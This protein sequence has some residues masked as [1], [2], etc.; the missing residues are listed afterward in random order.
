MLLSWQI[1]QVGYADMADGS[2]RY[3]VQGCRASGDMNTALGN[4]VLMCAI[5]H[6]YLQTLPCKWRFINDGD[7]CGI[8]MESD[9]VHYLDTLPA[10]HLG[11]GFEME[12]EPPV[13]CVEHVEF[14]QSRPIELNEGEWMMVRNVH[15]AMKNDWISINSH[16]W[17]STEEILH[18]TSLCGLALFGDV[19]VLGPMYAAM[20][21][22]GAREVVLERLM[23][24]KDGWRRHLTGHRKY[25]VDETIARVSLYRAFNIL[26]DEQQALEEVY[27]AFD[28]TNTLFKTP[29]S[30]NSLD[31]IRY[32]LD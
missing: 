15:K 4:V 19:P 17:C 18:A 23:Q 1:D 10:H 8:F 20:N 16:D 13:Y 2:V 31:R 21:R 12:V 11:Y 5:T 3:T 9:D 6:H 32:L 24:R 30:N 7:D 29:S 26:P 14:C 25:P 27:R 22:F 28:P